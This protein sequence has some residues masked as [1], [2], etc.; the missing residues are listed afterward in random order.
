MAKPIYD[1]HV[2][3]G[4]EFFCE[5]CDNVIKHGDI[6]AEV[7]WVK[8]RKKGIYLVCES[9]AEGITKEWEAKQ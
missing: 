8:Y 3:G 1:L 2:Y 9:C 6:Y 4:T 5:K 7:R